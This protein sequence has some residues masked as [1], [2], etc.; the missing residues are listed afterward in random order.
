MMQFH[1]NIFTGSKWGGYDKLDSVYDKNVKFKRGKN[2]VTLLSA[3]VGLKVHFN[4]K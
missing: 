1:K 2:Q 4:L 3:T